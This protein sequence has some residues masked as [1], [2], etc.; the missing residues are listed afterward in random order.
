MSSKNL[1][2]SMHIYYEEPFEEILMKGIR[3]FVEKLLLNKLCKHYFFIRYFED[4]SHIRLRLKT[5]R[6][7]LAK[8]QNICEKHFK[9]FLKKH[10]SFRVISDMNKLVSEKW[11]L[12]N[13]ICFVKYEPEL[14]RYGGSQG[15]AISEKQFEISSIAVLS[16]INASINWNYKKAL[17]EAI[18]LHLIFIHSMEMDLDEA[19]N[20]FTQIFTAKLNYYNL[21]IQFV[22]QDMVE[23]KRGHIMSKLNEAFEQQRNEI[24]KYVN[25]IWNYLESKKRF[26]KLYLNKWNTQSKVI[27]KKLRHALQKNNLVLPNMD[28]IN[29]IENFSPHTI[30]SYI[31]DSYIHMTN[32]RLGIKN[33]DEALVAFLIISSLKTIK[34]NYGKVE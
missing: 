11:V 20:F 17:S 6:T 24:V 26:E 31:F 22:P 15:L 9:R 32:N 18:R 34:I 4:G 23:K 21:Q 8:L 7:N 19:I 25:R 33:K 28:I 14:E 29:T 5:E 10:P 16:A 12:N 3:P 30:L 2:L 1:W 13:S 27:S